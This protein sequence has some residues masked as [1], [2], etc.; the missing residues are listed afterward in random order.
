MKCHTHNIEMVSYSP[1][2]V[3]GVVPMIALFR[4]RKCDAER[5]AKQSERETI[6]ALQQANGLDSDSPPTPEKKP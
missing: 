4:C 5:A 3:N 2:A 1:P 6:K